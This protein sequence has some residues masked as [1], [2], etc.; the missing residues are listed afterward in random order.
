MKRIFSLMLFVMISNKVIASV[1]GET[2][3]CDKDRRGYNFISK[4]EVKI[5]VI[6]LNELK[7]FFVNH[8]YEVADN[9]I[10]IQQPLSVLDKQET[11]RPIGWIFRRN[12][13]YVSLDYVNGDWSRKFL[14][15]CEITTS[16][17]LDKRIKNKLNELIKASG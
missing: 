8:S 14:W 10:F 16:E 9:A 15:S 3:I 5:S 2:L 7:T 6:N 1:E 13:D 11:H 12:L 17:Q 4:D